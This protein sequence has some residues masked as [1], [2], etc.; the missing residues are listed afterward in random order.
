LYGNGATRKSTDYRRGSIPSPIGL[1][2][3][4]LPSLPLF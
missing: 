1:I 2:M 4:E 3:L